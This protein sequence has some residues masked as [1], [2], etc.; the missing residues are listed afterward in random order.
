MKLKRLLPIMLMSLVVASC[1]GNSTEAESPALE[2]LKAERDSL[3]SRLT[4]INEKIQALDTNTRIINP[5]VS[6]EEVAVK[7]F[8][9]KIEIQ[10]SV[11]TDKNA[12]INSE[13]SGKVTS[14]HVQEG[15][16][17]SQGQALVTIDA[18][19]L[20]SQIQEIETQL[21]L[22]TYMYDKQKKLMD[23][24]VGTEI[25]YEQ[26]KA[27]K[28]SLEKSLQTMRSQR[29]KTV[30]RAPFSGV[31]D[32]V[33]IHM[34]EM[35]SPGVPLMRV[36]N[37]SDVKIT[38]SLSENYLAK[39]F[40]GTEVELFVPS[41]N[42]TTFA[43]KITSKGNFIDPV[44]RTFRIRIDI[45][46]NKLLLPNQLAKV[47]VTDYEKDS[48]TVINS[49]SI[50]QD[51]KNNSYIYKLVK[52]EGDVYD[53]QKVVIN[54][55]SQYQGEACIETVEGVINEGDKIVVKGAK[56]ITEADQVI[57]Q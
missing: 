55:L 14:V 22:A 6:A 50:L 2:A 29:G 7:K 41:L 20:S 1:G 39:V 5:L 33:M 8:K 47:Q 57:I 21:E 16:K 40:E 44:N 23:E 26:A 54:V 45:K 34:G 19:I 42:D 3:K 52:A 15:Q 43:S 17:V 25:E 35:A 56:G 48:A 49:E 38:A 32:E 53:V 28:N 13:A 24:G 30:V 27:Q 51:T 10:G 37:N 18:T 36:V 11:E 9:H 12:M 4:E 31:I 46:K